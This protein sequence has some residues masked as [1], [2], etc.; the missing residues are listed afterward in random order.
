[1]EPTGQIL[2]LKPDHP[3]LGLGPKF[4][5]GSREASRTE[6]G[7]W[8]ETSRGG[9]W[10]I[11]QG[12]HESSGREGLGEAELIGSACGRRPLGC[13]RSAELQ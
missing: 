3:H 1:M 8:G 5:S 4:G 12:Q 11:R 10:E 9:K 13:P 2:S 7:L 6:M